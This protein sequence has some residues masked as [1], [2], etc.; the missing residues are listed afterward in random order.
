MRYSR[1]LCTSR[2][3]H[4]SFDVVP[5]PLK[6]SESF[7]LSG[8]IT[9]ILSRIYIVHSKGLTLFHILALTTFAF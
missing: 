8:A 1:V 9:T 6:K 7:L 3:R 4:A 2:R 5:S